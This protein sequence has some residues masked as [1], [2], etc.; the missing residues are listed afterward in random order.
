MRAPGV[1]PGYGYDLASAECGYGEG[2]IQ[3]ECLG[4]KVITGARCAPS[5]LGEDGEKGTL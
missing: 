3:A 1:V 2:A 5:L 4:E